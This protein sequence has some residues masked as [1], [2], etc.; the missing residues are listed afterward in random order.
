MQVW[1]IYNQLL[2]WFWI[3]EIYYVI[4]LLYT[5]IINSWWHL[6]FLSEYNFPSFSSH[7]SVRFVYTVVTLD[8]IS[9]E[10]YQGEDKDFQVSPLNN[11]T[12]ILWVNLIIIGYLTNW[13]FSSYKFAYAFLR[14]RNIIAQNIR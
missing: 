14:K 9:Q 3:E 7:W 2:D 8:L 12:E 5:A 4:L 13:V 1:D 10:I 6:I 11:F